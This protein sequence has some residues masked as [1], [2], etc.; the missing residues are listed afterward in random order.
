MLKSKIRKQNAF[1]TSAFLLSAF[2]KRQAAARGRLENIS[3]NPPGV[4]QVEP[5]SD[6]R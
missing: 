6:H 2:F 5:T 3:P 1:L 4:C